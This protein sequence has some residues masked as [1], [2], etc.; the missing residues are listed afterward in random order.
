MNVLIALPVAT[1]L[2]MPALIISK[3]YLLKTFHRSTTADILLFAFVMLSIKSHAHG[4]LDYHH[5][6]KANVS[7]RF[8]PGY[9]VGNCQ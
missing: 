3:L 9:F 2:L 7:K 1:S 4:I 8:A 5:V 6:I